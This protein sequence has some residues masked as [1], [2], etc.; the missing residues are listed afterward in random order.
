MYCNWLTFHSSFCSTFPKAAK[1]G[2]FSFNA[3]FCPLEKK[4]QLILS[5]LQPP[6]CLSNN[7]IMAE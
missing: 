6:P 7:I 4:N 1:K 2:L 3:L 5:I